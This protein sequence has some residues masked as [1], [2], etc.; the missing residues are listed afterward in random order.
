[1]GRLISPTD[2]KWL[3]EFHP[4]LYY[5]PKL[6]I[7]SGE[8]SFDMEF[9]PDTQQHHIFYN[10][11]HSPKDLRIKDVYEIEIAFDNENVIPNVRE[12]GDKIKAVAKKYA[13]Q[14]LADLHVFPDGGLCLYSPIDKFKI[15]KSINSLQDFFSLILIPYLYLQSY[16][17][18]HKIW[19]WGERGHGIIGILENYTDLT[20]EEKADKSFLLYLVK[21]I[22]ISPYSPYLFR[23]IKRKN[24]IDGNKFYCPCDI[25]KKF[26]KC[27][28]KALAGLHELKRHL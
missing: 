17:A 20:H 15:E 13:I 21:S 23:L 19:L 8:L 14:N 25:N 26:S 1:M 18:E 4:D 2:I 5:D 7:I 16:F 22:S 27:H 6:N 11:K 3:N 9:N 12:Y 10:D 24:R 28:S